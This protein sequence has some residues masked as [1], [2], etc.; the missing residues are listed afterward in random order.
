MS[1]LKQKFDL[2]RPNSKLVQLRVHWN[3]DQQKQNFDLG[4]TKD[5]VGSDL[6]FDLI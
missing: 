6:S 4:W 2:N 1:S 3:L 5:W